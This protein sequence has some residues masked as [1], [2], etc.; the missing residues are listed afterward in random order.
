MATTQPTDTAP[1]QPPRDYRAEVTKEIIDLIE[2]GNA[3]WQKPWNPEMGMRSMSMPHNATTGRAYRGGNALH[4]MFKADALGSDDPRWCTF[5]QAKAKGWNIKK[6]SKGTLVEYWKFEEEQERINPDT[7]Q[8][9][10]VRVKLDRPTVFY[11][12]VFHASQIEGIPEYVPPTKPED[13]NPVAQAE[14][15]L[16]GSGAKIHHDQFDRAFYRPSTDAIHLPPVSAFPKP[17]DYYETA[18]HELSHWTGHGT[19]QNRDLSGAFGSESYAREELRAQM[20]SLFLSMEVGV[21]FNPERHA[22][23]QKSWVKVLADDKHEIFRAARD[24]ERIADY[25]MELALEKSNE[26]SQEQELAA[27]APPQAAEPVEHPSATSTTESAPE[28]APVTEPAVVPDGKLAQRIE[29][30]DF[31]MSKVPS[32]ATTEMRATSAQEAFHTAFGLTT[33]TSSTMHHWRDAGIN[34]AALA[35][36]NGQEVV[37]TIQRYVSNVAKRFV[38]TGSL[39]ELPNQN[40][41]LTEPNFNDFDLQK[42]KALTDDFLAK[43]LLVADN[44][45][46]FENLSRVL[47]NCELLGIESPST[48]QALIAQADQS[49]EQYSASRATAYL[50]AEKL[51]RAAEEI[52]L[53]NFTTEGLDKLHLKPSSSAIKGWFSA[54]YQGKTYYSDGKIMDTGGT[55]PHLRE[56]QKH[57]ASNAQ[58][59]LNID[60]ILPSQNAL[61]SA[62]PAEPIALFD[63]VTVT[64]VALSQGDDLPVIGVEQNYYRYFKNKYPDSTAFIDSSTSM[65]RVFFKRGDELVGIVMPM[66][67]SNDRSDPI[68]TASQLRAILLANAQAR[69]QEPAT[70]APIYGN[71]A[72]QRHYD[73]LIAQIPSGSS[74]EDYQHQAKAIFNTVFNA[75]DG[76]TPNNV[77]KHIEGIPLD[78]LKGATGASLVQAIA[79]YAASD[80]I[81]EINS[82]DVSAPPEFDPSSQ[83]SIERAQNT[84]IGMSRML[85]NQLDNAK[86]AKSFLTEATRLGIAADI[87]QDKLPK[88][89]AI[90]EERTASIRTVEQW[91]TENQNALSRNRERRYSTEGLDTLH[92]KPRSTAISGWFTGTLGDKLIHTNGHIID[93]TGTEPHLSGWETRQ[94]TT[95]RE[96]GDVSRIL[97]S[98]IALSDALPTKPLAVLKDDHTAMLALDNGEDFPVVGIQKSYYSYFKNKYPQAQAYLENPT[99]FDSRILFKQGD[100]LVGIAMPCKLGG[101][102]QY[103][104]LTGK[105]LAAI[106]ERNA[107]ENVALER[108]Q[109]QP[110]AATTTPAADD[111]AAPSVAQDDTVSQSLVSSIQLHDPDKNAI[112]Q[113]PHRTPETERLSIKQM[114]ENLRWQDVGSKDNIKTIRLQ[115]AHPDEPFRFMTYGSASKYLRDAFGRWTSDSTLATNSDLSVI[116]AIEVSNATKR[117]AKD[118]YVTLQALLDYAPLDEKL[119]STKPKPSAIEGWRTSTSEDGQTTVYVTNELLDLS[120]T[121]PHLSK[122]QE[123]INE[124]KPTLAHSSLDRVINKEAGQDRITLS[125]MAMTF[126]LRGE[127]LVALQAGDEQ[128]TCYIDAKFVAYLTSKF[129]NELTYTTTAPK[130]VACTDNIHVLSGDK[131]LAVIAPVNLQDN[132]ATPDAIRAELQMR[133]ALE[134]EAGLPSQAITSAQVTPDNDTRQAFEVA[135]RKVYPTFLR[136]GEKLLPYWG[137]QAEENIGKEHKVGGDTLHLTIEDATTAAHHEAQAAAEKAAALIELQAQQERKAQEDKAKAFDN[138]NGFTK[139]KMPVVTGKIKKALSKEVSIDGIKDTLRQHIERWSAQGNLTLTTFE[140]NKIKPMSSRDFFNASHAEQVAHEK[141]VKAGG[142]QTV[143][144]VNNCDLGKTAYE[145]AA[146]MQSTCTLS[147]AASNDKAVFTVPTTATVVQIK[148][149]NEKLSMQERQELAVR[150]SEAVEAM[151]Q[152]QSTLQPIYGCVEACVSSEEDLGELALPIKAVVSDPVLAELAKSRGL[153]SIKRI[154]EQSGSFTMERI[155]KPTIKP[156]PQP[157]QAKEHAPELSI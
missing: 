10:M 18:L 104:N 95:K 141:R 89:Q 143:Y 154:N 2:Q 107:L 90:L 140:E 46:A 28:P 117:L 81:L 93:L 103:E 134:H 99:N 19:R 38:N 26:Y 113:N 94:S 150:L 92:L 98:S 145:Y 42:I 86:S 144:L 139:G 49:R 47:K 32:D 85:S 15:I 137:V 25:V 44:A 116:K 23:Y 29:L 91:L 34:G 136:D 128:A 111:T 63:Q 149:F 88:V 96:I 43:A 124:D 102:I 120:G 17:E 157:E 109:E 119:L 71:E 52:H 48:T 146:H 5:K 77:W 148:D 87:A 78:N 58:N 133:A 127:P 40:V 114:H 152:W 138:L 108:Q 8:P 130:E 35:D 69:P 80:A 54:E 61:K 64:A 33:D 3:R 129:G 60:R 73:H 27:I 76:S 121:P 82:T 122:W 156:A 135:G 4:L 142:K 131:L 106:L 101:G 62:V 147:K 55:E 112:F 97:P 155:Y 22:A 50:I 20:A 41:D 21:P 126:G 9:E 65:E 115:F 16:K 7:Q 6:G 31:A 24:A 53:R 83:E 118:G 132:S 75:A 110:P 79:S 56:W 1:Q 67:F 68:P 153:D 123:H 70:P 74:A 72:I 100:E 37:N 66:R 36:M 151:P 13:W 125:P 59:A 105:E 84:L 51:V 57:A 45:S 30:Y 39:L 14:N 12:S 11:G